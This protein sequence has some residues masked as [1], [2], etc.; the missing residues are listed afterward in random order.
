MTVWDDVNAYYSHP[1]AVWKGAV[2]YDKTSPATSLHEYGVL[3][4]IQ[5][6]SGERMF[7]EAFRSSEIRSVAWDVSNDTDFLSLEE[8][9]IAGILDINNA[10]FIDDFIS[11]KTCCNHLHIKGSSGMNV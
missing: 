8:I 11:R 7:N 6:Y 9:E 3:P 10:R 1:G 4:K 5:F 2:A